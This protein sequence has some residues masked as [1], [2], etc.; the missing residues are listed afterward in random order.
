V[1]G[2]GRVTVT[3][4]PRA[5]NPVRLPA[6]ARL[7]DPLSETPQPVVVRGRPDHKSINYFVAGLRP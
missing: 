5:D 1:N 7:P 4:F 3:I 2:D 6:Q